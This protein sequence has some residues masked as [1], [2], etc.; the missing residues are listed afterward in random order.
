MP[1]AMIYND[2][3]RGDAPEPQSASAYDAALNQIERL[4][5]TIELLTVQRD[6]E[7][8]RADRAEQQIAEIA[9]R[10]TT[11]GQHFATITKRTTHD[12]H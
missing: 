11:L 10:L 3:A 7:A 8:K 5:Q 4:H 2:M 1:D 9:D 12:R 6:V